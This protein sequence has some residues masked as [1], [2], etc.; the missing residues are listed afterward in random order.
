M[1]ACQLAAGSGSGPL[2]SFPAFFSCSF[3]AFGSIEPKAK[4]NAKQPSAFFLHRIF[5]L[6][7]KKSCAKKKEYQIVEKNEKKNRK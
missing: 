1:H 7:K 2:F 3:L 4:K 5:F 6:Q